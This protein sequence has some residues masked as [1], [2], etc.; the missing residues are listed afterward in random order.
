MRA[1]TVLW[2]IILLV[3]N[4]ACRIEIAVGQGL[5]PGK[6][7]TQY[8]HDSWEGKDGLPQNSVQAICQTRDGYLWL[9]TYEG[10]ARFDGFTFKVYDRNNTPELLSNRIMSLTEDH[11]GHLWI[12]TY[13]GGLTEMIPGAFGAHDSFRTYTRGDGLESM[14]F[15]VNEM[16]CDSMDNIWFLTDR[17]EITRFNHKTFEN[18]R[19]WRRSA[20]PNYA[21]RAITVDRGGKLWCLCEGDIYVY[22]EGVFR[23]LP[24]ITAF[25]KVV[26]IGPGAVEGIWAAGAAKD[27]TLRLVHIV[28]DSLRVAPPLNLH[29]PSE[30]AGP[31]VRIFED[32]NGAVWVGMPVGKLVRNYG[33][34]AELMTVRDGLTSQYIQALFQDREGSLWIGADGGGL[35]RLRDAP[36][37]T[38]GKPEGLI[39]E[40]IEM[41]FADSKENVWVGALDHSLYSID[42]GRSRNPAAAPVSNAPVGKYTCAAEDGSGN[43][44]FSGTAIL[45]HDGRMKKDTMFG[46]PN[47]LVTQV[48]RRNVFWAGGQGE[49]L[50]RFE[51]GVREHFE[52]SDGLVGNDVRSLL[53]DDQ[54]I[55]YVGTQE[56]LSV[57][58]GKSFRNYTTKDGLP[59]DWIRSMYMD[60]EGSLWLA[61]DGGLGRL[62]GN[63]FRSYG[64]ASRELS[65][66][67]H[68]VLEDDS[69]RLWMSSNKGVFLV[70]KRDL[71]GFDAGRVSSVAVR[72]YDE[73]DGMRSA[74]GNGTF[75]EGGC[76]T[77]DG[78][79]WFATVK[80]VVEVNPNDIPANDVVPPVV[81]ERVI[82]QDHEVSLSEHPAFPYGTK[83]MEFD[84]AAL[85]YRNVN[86][87]TYRYRLDGYDRG[88]T[89]EKH[90]TRVTYLG[91]SPGTYTFRVTGANDDGLWNPQGAKV[92][93][94]IAAP[95][96]MTWWFRGMMLFFALSVIAWIIKH[97]EVR[98]IKLQL[99]R[100]EHEHALERERS[101]ISKDLHDDVGSMLTKI[102]F[103]ST[104]ACKSSADGTRSMEK[105]STTAEEAVKKMDEIV[106]AVN[107]RNDN[108]KN[109]WAYITEYAAELFDSTPV[110]PRFEF[111]AEIPDMVLAS[112]LRHN[113][114]LVVKES[115]SNVLKHSRAETVRLR[116]DVMKGLI[117]IVVSD[118]GVGIDH[119]A[120]NGLG[121]GLKNMAERIE[122]IGGGLQI[123]QAEPSGTEI[124]V[125]FKANSW[126]G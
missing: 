50:Y 9:G 33:N 94:T 51:N 112:D 111:P 103:L 47:L 46:N 31:F 16:A 63:R 26:T 8:I 55:L 82:A 58:D 56:G 61:T 121:N 113:V 88:W 40:N 25:R 13:G 22:Q 23:R 67:I 102:L 74:E 66:I 17:E 5:N 36:F 70:S 45:T 100:M 39:H 91:L 126:K 20:N 18:Y 60:A 96:W 59:N 86:R 76:R 37:A 69:S 49:G 2:A 95:F 21:W 10:L 42:A 78:Q 104:A 110:A 89:E 117:R 122:K 115:L 1:R 6:R 30:Y 35:N 84:F 93:F 32:K 79:L 65:G 4:L 116:L 7:L 68:V 105:I 54:N 125:E 77:A 81:I 98:R 106:W 48:D 28:G 11:E 114:F 44:F 38:I 87:N 80:G 101:R 83:K 107:P 72:V 97:V 123:R 29:F 3:V 53:V 73:S 109:L 14:F 24:G 120:K 64:K 52:M 118:N 108:L 34:R 41:L 19:P 43:I 62:K 57:F 90:R 92:T 75:P 71:D 124:A 15:A 119:R 12:G 27:G 99:R 85:S